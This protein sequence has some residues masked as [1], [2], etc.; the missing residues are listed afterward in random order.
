MN[1]NQSVRKANAVVLFFCILLFFTNGSQPNSGFISV[2]E[3]HF[4]AMGNDYY[5]IGANFWYGT[6]LG[7]TTKAGDRERL[8]DELDFLASKGI[9]N[10]RIMVGADLSEFHPKRVTPALQTSPG[11]YNENLFEGLD[12][13][14]TEMSK[15]KMYAVLYLTNS[16][17][18]SG[19]YGQYLEWNG[20]GPS[21]SVVDTNV[22]WN[23]FQAYTMQFH[24]CQPCID[25]YLAHIKKIVSR[26]NSISG[27]PFKDD[28]T[29]M[30]WQ[31]GNEPRAFSKEAI[32]AFENNMKAAARLIKSIDNNHL[33]SVG[34]E[35]IMGC[36][37]SMELFERLHSIPEVDYLT[38]HIWPKNWRWIDE[39]KLDSTLDIAVLKTEAYIESHVAI[40][41]KLQKPLVIEEFG[42]P[43]DGHSYTPMSTTVNRDKYYESIFRKVLQSAA[44]KENLSGCNFWSYGGFG[45][46]GTKTLPWFSPGDDLLG[47]P[48]CEEQGLNSVFDADKTINMI[49]RYNFLFRD[50][51]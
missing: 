18:W 39:E 19:G 31:L 11:V 7:S 29:I 26:K 45:R 38:I 10:L 48:P 51:H 2:K 16:W 49:E 12:Y 40:A 50:K 36:E 21:L 22:S 3:G 24:T 33:V 34:S 44:S 8:I 9:D 14:L 6:I 15:R 28:P 27:L 13:L 46:P 25:Q 20:Y 23:D 47:D 35:G 17:D 5:Y 32:P 37:G 42:F 41:K 4:Y 43:R 1:R 30:A